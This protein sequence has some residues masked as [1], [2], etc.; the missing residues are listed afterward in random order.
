MKMTQEE[1]EEYL[2]RFNEATDK[3]QF[4]DQYYDPNVVFIHPFKGVFKGKDEL[5][6]FWSSGENCG[7]EGI[8]EKLFLKNFIS[9]EGK[10]AVE[11]DIEWFCF[12]D[13]EYLGQRKKGDLFRGKCA[14]FFEFSGNKISHVRLY[15]N[16][17]EQA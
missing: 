13:A 16:I 7:H 3:S 11:V 4:F 12:K 14:N 5:V 15:L 2:N 9:I 17:I 1:F 6:R 8:R 10:M